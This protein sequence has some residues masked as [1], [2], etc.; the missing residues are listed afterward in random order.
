MDGYGTIDHEAIAQNYLIKRGFSEKI[1]QLVKNHVEA[2]RYL[3]WKD[4]SYH[5]KLSDASKETLIRQGGPM[6]NDEG[7]IDICT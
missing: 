1:C 7:V 3:C 6:S 4:K 2:K 5:S